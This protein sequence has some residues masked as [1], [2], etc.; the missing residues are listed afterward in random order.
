MADEPQPLQYRLLTGEGD[1]AFCE[2]VS[3]ALAEGYELHGAPSIAVEAGLVWV[4]QAVVRP[5]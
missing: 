4:A 3:Q 5:A 2:R 1:R